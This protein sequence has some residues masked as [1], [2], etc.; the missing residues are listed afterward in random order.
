MLK[1]LVGMGIEFE[2]VGSL[3]VCVLFSVACLCVCVCAGGRFLL[4]MP[5]LRGDLAMARRI[6]EP[7]HDN[8]LRLF[9]LAP[10]P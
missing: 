7:C 4:G 10:N 6:L 8:L 2:S 1:C 9:F 3:E 5:G